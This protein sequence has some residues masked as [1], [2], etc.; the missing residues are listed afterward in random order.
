MWHDP[1]VRAMQ[2][3]LSLICHSKNRGC[4]QSMHGE[5]CRLR[6]QPYPFLA[7]C[8]QRA[9]LGQLTL[10]HTVPIFPV[11]KYA[12]GTPHIST[13]TDNFADKSK[14]ICYKE[15]TNNKLAVVSVLQC[16]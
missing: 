11:K 6:Q 5:A 3:A 13:P 8:I 12:N 1:S 9:N 16:L 2:A 4:Q 14:T 15:K 7:N 10:T